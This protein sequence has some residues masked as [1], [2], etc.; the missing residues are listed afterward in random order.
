MIHGLKFFYEVVL[1]RKMVSIILPRKKE[2]QKLPDILSPSEVKKIIQCTTNL[3]YR[4]M[5]I[6]AYGA[7]LRASE[8]VSLMVKDIDSERSVIHIRH[9]KGGKDRYVML[10][11]FMLDSLR[12][13]WKECRLQISKRQSN[14]QQKE[15]ALSTSTH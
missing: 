10:S 11:P 7:G 13:Y 14:H 3:K 2:P 4:T 6:I 1:N 5:L 15:T 8:L 9:G 12:I